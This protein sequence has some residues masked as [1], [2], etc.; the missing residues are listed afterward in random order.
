MTTTPTPATKRPM[1]VWLLICRIVSAI[2]SA[3]AIA[4]VLAGPADSVMRTVGYVLG[5]IGLTA[6]V[7]FLAFDQLLGGVRRAPKK[8]NELEPRRG[9]FLPPGA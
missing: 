5:I 8:P 3:V 1:R 9:P 4:L 6:L 2:V 7:G